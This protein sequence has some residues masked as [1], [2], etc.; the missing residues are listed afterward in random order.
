MGELQMS[1]EIQADE[2]HQW[3]KDAIIMKGQG[4]HPIVYGAKIHKIYFHSVLL[5]NSP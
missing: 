4:K 2:G 5:N 1:R 3:H